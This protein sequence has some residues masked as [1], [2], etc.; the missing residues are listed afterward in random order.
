MEKVKAS[1]KALR[2]LINNSIIETIG[3]LELPPPS[4][5]IK[6]LVGKSSKRLAVA[7]NNIIKSELKK[8]KSAEKSLQ[9][10]EKALKGKKKSSKKTELIKK[11]A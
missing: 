11:E 4:K 10:V 6:K 8:S 7:F 5:K 1:K 2:E 3:K 9:L